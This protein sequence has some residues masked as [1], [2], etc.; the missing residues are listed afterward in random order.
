MS[1]DGSCSKNNAGASVWI[2]NT[3]KGHACKLD[4]LCTNNIAKYEALLLGLH[5]LKELKAKK[6]SIQG[7]SE[8]II[9]QIKGEYSTKNPRL[10]EYRNTILD[11]LKTFE[12]YELMFIPRAQ[13]HLENKLAFAASNFQIRQI[14]EQ[15]IMKVENRPAVPDNEDHWQV[16]NNDKH[17]EDFL[18]SK[19]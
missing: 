2:H 8:L 15:I 9:R 13:N 14:D 18:Q 16:F 6:I 12:K 3:N 10:R 1:F 19:N 11:L 5:I 7:D 17:I 4:F